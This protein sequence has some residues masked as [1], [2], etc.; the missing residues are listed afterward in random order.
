MHLRVDASIE[1]LTPE[2]VPALGI[3]ES[4]VAQV[5]LNEDMSGAWE[6]GIR[7]T[8]DAELN[9]LNRA[10]R[11]V[12]A[13]TDVLSFGD[14]DPLPDDDDDDTDDADDDDDDSFDAANAA[15]DADAESDADDDA[16]DDA[17]AAATA[18]GPSSGPR[19]LGDLAISYERVVAQAAEY[20][21]S[22]RRELCYLVAHGTLHLLGFDHETEAERAAMREREEAALDNLGITRDAEPPA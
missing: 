1:V 8:D 12:D 20:G 3:L 2:A 5:L 15:D 9:E 22:V 13:P 21:H 6:I 19:Y 11:A 18:G 4:V 10:Y 16:D 17:D 14:Y 7:I